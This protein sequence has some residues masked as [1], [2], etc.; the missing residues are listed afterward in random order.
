MSAIHRLPRIPVLLLTMTLCGLI[1]SGLAPKDRLTWFLEI[2]P[3]VVILPVLIATYPRHSLTP[4]LYWLLALHAAVL[5]IGG[6]YTYAEVPAGR[7]VQ[8]TFGLARNPYDRLGH[9]V[10]GFVPGLFMREWLLKSSP[11]QPGRWLFFLV[12]STALAFS[13]LYELFEWRV[14]VAL[15]QSA[16]EF[17]GTQG[18][19][20]D[21]QW[22][23][24]MALIGAVTAQLTL[25]RLHNQQ[26]SRR[27]GSRHA[28]H[29]RQQPHRSKLAGALLLT[30]FVSGAHPAWAVPELAPAVR[31][32]PASISRSPLDQEHL[33]LFDGSAFT[34]TTGRCTDCPTPTQ[35]LW[36][37]TEE[38]VV[39][40]S[41]GRSLNNSTFSASTRRR[42]SHLSGL[43]RRS[44]SSTA[45][46]QTEE[47]LVMT[48]RRLP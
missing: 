42:R 40:P 30:A 36:Y 13:A 7:W 26:L 24:G 38:I 44:R 5:I 18:D 11:L 48:I 4:L 19:E 15:G 9:F 17:L 28:A 12:C 45:Q 41:T 43:D 10:Q 3:I 35:A 25:A 1:A 33:G 39:I 2:L 27:P 14:A 8:E 37:F 34:L 47:A 16:M 20:W 21:T 23:M 22:D 32:S 6:H 31:P 46:P 29:K